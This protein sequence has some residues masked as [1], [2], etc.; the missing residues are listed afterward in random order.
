MALW[1]F[2]MNL[3]PAQIVCEVYGTVLTSIAMEIA[4][5]FPWWSKVQPPTGFERQIDSILPRS[6]PCFPPHLDLEKAKGLQP[7]MCQRQL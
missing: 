5:D 2:R 6:H 7:A 1:Q 4:E 3:I